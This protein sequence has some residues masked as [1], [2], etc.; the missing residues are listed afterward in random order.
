LSVLS[1]E[2]DDV[3]KLRQL[4]EQ[5]NKNSNGTKYK[6]TATPFKSSYDAKGDRR[7]LY[8][9]WN[10]VHKGESSELYSLIQKALNKLTV[11]QQPQEDNSAALDPN[12]LPDVGTDVLNVNKDNPMAKMAHDF[13]AVERDNRI[14]MIAREL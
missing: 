7:N 8:E 3:N 6:F 14:H 2:E 11:V 10:G 4:A 13:S 5:L 12:N 1:F 9:E